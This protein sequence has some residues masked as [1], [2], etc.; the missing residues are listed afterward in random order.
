VLLGGV[1]SIAKLS[2][3]LGPSR[4]TLM[5]WRRWWTRTFPRTTL[6]REIVGRMLMTD[7]SDLP[8][9]LLGR[10]LGSASE[11]VLRMLQIL[12]PLSIT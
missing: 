4:R 10:V 7:S 1:G 11:H 9:A 5:R 2:K 12:K 8:S 6:F 3:Q